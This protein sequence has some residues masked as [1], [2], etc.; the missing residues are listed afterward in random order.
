MLPRWGTL[1]TY[2]SAL[3][4]NRLR[5]PAMGNLGNKKTKQNVNKNNIQNITFDLVIGRG[6]NSWPT[7]ANPIVRHFHLTWIGRS[8]VR[9]FHLS[10][11]CRT[12]RSWSDDKTFWMMSVEIFCLNSWCFRIFSQRLKFSFVCDCFSVRLSTV[13]IFTSCFA[14]RWLEL[15]GNGNNPMGIPWEWE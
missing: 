5:S 7:L 13:Y 9:H 10:W 2:G 11:K 15:G 6:S 4:T 3:V 8:I 12:L 14:I 1:L